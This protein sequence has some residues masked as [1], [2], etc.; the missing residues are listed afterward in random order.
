VTDAQWEIVDALI[1]AMPEDAP[2]V[3]SD[4]REI[5]HAVL[6]VLRS[7]CP[8][9]MRPQDFPA[10]GT[11]HWSVRRWER[12]GVWDQVLQTLRKRV[13]QKQGRNEEAS[14]AVIESQAITTSAV[15]GPE[16]GD[17]AGT[18]NLGAHTARAR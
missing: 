18:K 5:V 8:W 1:P 15:R 6:D 4:R 17:D 3:L 14:A 11:V 2:H 16:K 12:E 13:R 9:R 7:G 10:W